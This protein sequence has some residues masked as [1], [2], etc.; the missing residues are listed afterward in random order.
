MA[1]H[2]SRRGEHGSSHGRRRSRSLRHPQD[3]TGRKR[4]LEASSGHEAHPRK[5]TRKAKASFTEE[6]WKAL[7]G[8]RCHK[9]NG[10]HSTVTNDLGIC[11][12]CQRAFHAKC[13]SPEVAWFGDLASEWFCSDCTSTM[14]RQRG[15]LQEQAFC[16]VQR[17]RDPVPWP[18]RVV[19]IDF[20]STKD[21]RPYWVQ[22]F[23]SG[24]L[25]GD[26]VG[27]RHVVPWQSDKAPS[28]KKLKQVKQ[29]NAV[30][31]AEAA[32]APKISEA[33]KPDLEAGLRQLRERMKMLVDKYEVPRASFSLNFL[34][35]LD[36]CVFQ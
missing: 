14:A 30:L 10:N 32:G 13:H 9:C 4:L 11:D 15:L 26:W 29:R 19:R 35:I 3:R 18:A 31:L 2:R 22:F 25:E 7:E 20:S 34:V 8:A 16:W 6:A 36:V 12:G 5:S 24:P 27:T 21:P 28:F 1:G 23:N 33:P 17:T